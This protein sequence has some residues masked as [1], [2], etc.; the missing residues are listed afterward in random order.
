VLEPGA[1]AEPRALRQQLATRL[2]APMLPT[3]FLQA[4]SLPR[5]PNG[6]RDR[7]AL[8]QWPAQALPAAVG[9]PAPAEEP[10]RTA[11]EAL[12]AEVWSGLLDGVAID[13]DASFFDHGGDSLL[14]LRMV[15]QVED[16]CG[17]RLP[18]L[19]VGQSSLRGLARELD[20]GRREPPIPAPSP[21]RDT[22]LGRLF[23]RSPSARSTEP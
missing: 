23:G 15:Q 18:L 6:K 14:A 13:P 21:T 2:P 11:S 9:G 4:E 20:G 16:A 1:T 3:C 12:L 5:L 7:E 10:P 17:L 19:R 22:W 8:A